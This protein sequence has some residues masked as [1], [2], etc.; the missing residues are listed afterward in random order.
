MI[1][2]YAKNSCTALCEAMQKKLPREVR[3]II[4][5]HIF[6]FKRLAFDEP[7]IVGADI[8]TTFSPRRTWAIPI[9]GDCACA[10]CTESSHALRPERQPDCYG[11]VLQGTSH[12]VVQHLH[13]AEYV[14][15]AIISELG[16]TFYR[17]TTLV[18]HDDAS[19]PVLLNTQ[20]GLFGL[21]PRNV[22]RK[23]EV[24]V[25]P[26]DFTPDRLLRVLPGSFWGPPGLRSTYF[27][28]TLHCAKEL[29]QLQK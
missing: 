25:S 14:P 16:E 24:Y 2:A 1:D 23:I 8:R 5:G 20:T 7:R 27:H 12:A 21:E 19:I 6:N 4:Y 11:P 26:N 18:L 28:D 22:A 17:T 9:V 29:A 10:A 13:D 3:D 15:S